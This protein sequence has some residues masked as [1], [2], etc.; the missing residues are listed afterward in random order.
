MTTVA[1]STTRSASPEEVRRALREVSEIE[2]LD[3]IPRRDVPLVVYGRDPAQAR[4]AVARLSQLGYRDV[5][6]LEA[7]DGVALSPPRDRYRR[8][9]EGTDVD[10]DAMR[11]YLE[12]EYG[13]VAQLRR[14]GTH[15]FAPLELT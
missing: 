14:D 10:P 6:Q 5:C 1:G 3:R 2:A 8:P 13:L 11:A 15:R 9:Y 4:Q 12:W 7:G